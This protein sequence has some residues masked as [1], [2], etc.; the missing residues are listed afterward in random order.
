MIVRRRRFITIAALCMAIAAIGSCVPTPQPVGPPQDSGVRMKIAGGEIILQMSLDGSKV[1][2]AAVSRYVQTAAR[3]VSQYL[4]RFPV[5]QVAVQVSVA[6]AGSEI[7][8]KELDGTLIQLEV[9][10]KTLDSD[11]DGDWTITH[12]MFHLAFPQLAERHSWMNEGL[13]DYLEPISRAQIGTL[14]PRRIW[15]DFV[16]GMPQ[17]LPEPGDAGLDNTHTW[18]RTYWGGCLYWLLADVH[19]R[20]QTGNRKSLQDAIRAIVDAGGDGRVTWEISRVIEIG[21]R[22]TGTTVLRDL[23]DQMGARPFAPDLTALWRRL[24]IV[25]AHG[26]VSFDDQAPLASIRRAMT[27]P[28]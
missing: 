27:E 8:G 12:E 24:G 10:P 25:Y 5:P 1:S 23:H 21:D 2:A 11:I 20:E 3:A 9:G 4:A 13:S 22:A 14:T 26:R 7:H 18:G 15:K 6:G 19:I 28:Q 17:G 16:E